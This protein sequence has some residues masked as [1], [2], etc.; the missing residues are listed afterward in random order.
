MTLRFRLGK[1]P[2]SVH[3]WFFATTLFLNYGLPLYGLVLWTAVVLVSVLVHELGHAGAVVAFGLNPQID[4]H[5]LG[6]TTSW[7]G[8]SSLSYGKRIV[9]SLAGPAMGFVAGGVAVAL[10]KSGVLPHTP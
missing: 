3:P 2:V 5:G 1:I 10:W 4:L 6:G 9:I 8:G 7:P